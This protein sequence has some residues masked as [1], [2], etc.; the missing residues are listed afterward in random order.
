MSAVGDQVQLAFMPFRAGCERL[1]GTL[2]TFHYIIHTA[3]PLPRLIGLMD[4]VNV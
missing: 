2:C 3:G 4:G 1:A